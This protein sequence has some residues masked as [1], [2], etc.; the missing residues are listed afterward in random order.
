MSKKFAA[1]AVAALTLASAT[2]ASTNPA[3]AKGKFGP[4]FGFGIAA[5][6]LLGAA[7][8]SS[9]YGGPVYVGPSYRCRWVQQFDRWG[10]YLGTAKVCR[11]W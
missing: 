2:L 8:V 6:T 10:Y 3:D 9:A 11:H 4:A 5:G 7:A 1:V